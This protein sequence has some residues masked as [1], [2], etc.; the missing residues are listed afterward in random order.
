MIEDSIDSVSKL[1]L[2]SRVNRKKLI[3]QHQDQTEVL[4]AQIDEVRIAQ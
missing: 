2:E 4:V 3:C 1:E